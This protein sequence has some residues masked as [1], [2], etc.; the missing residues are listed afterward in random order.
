MWQGVFAEFRPGLLSTEAD[1]S[2]AEAELGF[3][4]PAS[5]RAF[6]QECGAGRIGGQLRI[7]TPVSVPSAD[8]VTRAHVVAHS[9][10]VAIDSL[11][12]NP[13]TRDEP[14]RFTIEGDADAALMERAA[15]FGETTGGSFLFWDVTP[16][17]GEYEI[18]ALDADLETIHFGG[19]DLLA[20]V[21]GLQGAEIL[22]ILGGADAPLPSLFE[23]D[24]EAALARLALEAPTGDLE[25]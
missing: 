12:E 23:G 20:L 18:W 8:I 7:A 9:V 24:D 11:S 3:A 16:G 2:R 19:T 6:A 5:Y 21:R 25:A 4:L 15:F 22:H 10:A 17:V 13:L 14:H 1:L